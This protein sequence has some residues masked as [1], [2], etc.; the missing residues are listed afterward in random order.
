VSFNH[1]VE[2][3][4]SSYD[5]AEISTVLSALGSSW[6]TCASMLCSSPTVVLAVDAAALH[7]HPKHART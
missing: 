3:L 4:M 7:A 6:W 2:T 1:P 5:A